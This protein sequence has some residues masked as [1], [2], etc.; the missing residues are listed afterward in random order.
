MSISSSSVSFSIFILTFFPRHPRGA[1]D[2]TD[3]VE[4]KDGSSVAATDERRNVRVKWVRER[5]PS[6]SGQGLERRP[7]F[8]HEG[9]LHALRH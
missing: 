4:R 2:E 8:F 6:G 1:V 5:S 9:G 7:G 3:V